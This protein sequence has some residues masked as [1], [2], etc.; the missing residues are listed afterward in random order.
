M[1]VVPVAVIGEIVGGGFGVGI[2]PPQLAKTS[3]RKSATKQATNCRMRRMFMVFLL[4][5]RW[6]KAYTVEILP[7]GQF[8]FL[9]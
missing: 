3:V 9:Q 1:V 4:L 5:E 6:V 7:S 8:I 2:A